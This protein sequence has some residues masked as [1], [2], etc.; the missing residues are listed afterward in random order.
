VASAA[1]RSGTERNLLLAVRY[2]LPAVVFVA[3]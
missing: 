2:A 1:K 3:G